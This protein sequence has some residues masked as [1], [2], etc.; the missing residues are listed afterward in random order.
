M[1]QVCLE[2]GYHSPLR[3]IAEVLF[4]HS[5]WQ[6]EPSTVRFLLKRRLVRDAEMPE[7]RNTAFLSAAEFVSLG[8]MKLLVKLGVRLDGAM[9]GN[10]RGVAML[11]CAASFEN[12]KAVSWLLRHGHPVDARSGAT[13]WTPLMSAAAIPA[14]HDSGAAAVACIRELLRHGADP[15]ARAAGSGETVLGLAARAGNTAAVKLPLLVVRRDPGCVAAAATAAVGPNGATLLTTLASARAYGGDHPRAPSAVDRMVA[16]FAA[17]IARGAAHL[18]PERGVDAAD[19]SGRTALLAAARAGRPWSVR[20]LCAAGADPRATMGD[21]PPPAADSGG[22]PVAAAAL[23]GDPLLH[24]GRGALHYA[25][26]V[27]RGDPWEG[28]H[29]FGDEAQLRREA[30]ADHLLDHPC[31]GA[32]LLLAAAEGGRGDTPLEAWWA[33]A[34]AAGAGGG[35]GGGAGAPDWD[36]GAPENVPVPPGTRAAAL[37]V[38]RWPRGRDLPGFLQRDAAAKALLLPPAAAA[39]ERRAAVLGIGAEGLRQAQLAAAVVERVLAS[40]T[41]V[42]APLPAP[43]GR[44]SKPS[45]GGEEGRRGA[46]EKDEAKRRRRAENGDAEEVDEMRLLIA[47]CRAA[48]GGALDFAWAQHQGQQLHRSPLERAA[49]A[50]AKADACRRAYGEAAA[51]TIAA[52]GECG[53]PPPAGAGLGGSEHRGGRRVG[54]RKQRKPSWAGGSSSAALLFGGGKKEEE[55]A[56]RADMKLY[57]DIRRVAALSWIKAALVRAEAELRAAEAALEAAR[58][59]A[60]EQAE[61]MRALL[62][63][64][65]KGGAAGHHATA[66]DPADA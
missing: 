23:A 54:R 16:A 64:W 20:A 51:R 61:R 22:A 56:K 33:Q 45:G 26:A 35:G 32:G 24:V 60:V 5:L 48:T 4:H 34:I 65:R 13:G 28:S 1:M 14:H 27:V 42:P 7:G 15:A 31:G 38:A 52:L 57:A 19:A 39:A 53:S 11:H 55:R 29:R 59:D 36:A 17:A 66:T 58:A 40:V 47:R 44:A 6:D 50:R 49:L 63:E 2:A 12:A 18:A 62:A 3:G 9:F 8:C 10:S 25:L 46:S 43:A 21:V 41:V 37:A 30:C